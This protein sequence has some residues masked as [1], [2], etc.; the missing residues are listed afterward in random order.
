MNKMYI[1]AG[2]HKIAEGNGMIEPDGRLSA[3]PAPKA[4]GRADADPMQDVVDAVDKM[5]VRQKMWVPEVTF[6]VKKVSKKVRRL[7]HRYNRPPRLPR[8]LKKAARH[9][10]FKV[11]N[12]DVKSNVPLQPSST[13]VRLT[14]NYDLRVCI[15]PAGYPRTR[16]VQRLATLV[17]HKIA[18]HYQQF[19]MENVKGTVPGETN[20]C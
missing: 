9:A 20:F 5:N 8:K 14:I 17:N 3:A 16:S 18:L 6:S 10:E 1:F 12:L 4:W 19:I 13:D 7:M 15:T 2:S 11:F